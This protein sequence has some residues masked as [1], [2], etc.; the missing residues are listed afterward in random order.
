MR[1]ASIRSTKSQKK[2]SSYINTDSTSFFHK[3]VK[4]TTSAKTDTKY[5]ALFF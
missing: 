1:R 5:A 3:R 4:R 2:I